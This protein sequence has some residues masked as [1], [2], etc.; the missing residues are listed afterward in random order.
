MPEN[1]LFYP[2]FNCLFQK[3]SIQFFGCQ[4]FTFS[5]FDKKKKTL[6][7]YFNLQINLHLCNSLLIG[8]KCPKPDAIVFISTC[9]QQQYGRLNS[10][11]SQHLLSSIK[12]D[13]TSPSDNG[14]IGFYLFFFF[15]CFD[16]KCI[17]FITKSKFDRK[18]VKINL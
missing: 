7:R 10:S 16:I 9:F 3:H 8:P 12:S 2:I 4:F 13:R 1:L 6:N 14:F 5:F 18:K 11:L 15:I 17:Q